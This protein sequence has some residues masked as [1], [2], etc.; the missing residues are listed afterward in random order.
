MHFTLKYVMSCNRIPCTRCA[1]MNFGLQASVGLR[2]IHIL[3][4]SKPVLAVHSLLPRLSVQLNGGFPGS[5][6][7]IL[8]VRRIIHSNSKSDTKLI[9][10]GTSNKQW[11]FLFVGFS[12]AVFLATFIRT[13][14]D[15]RSAKRMFEEQIET[16]TDVPFPGT[17]KFSGYLL[18]PFVKSCLFDLKAF[19]V[20]DDDTFVVSYPKSGKW[21]HEFH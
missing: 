18:P 2:N 6:S 19:A 3:S 9:G 4:R 11:I 5:P 7:S 8:K 14:I 20:R 13:Q 12:A 17:I 1:R 16:L 10:K 15:K 21:Y